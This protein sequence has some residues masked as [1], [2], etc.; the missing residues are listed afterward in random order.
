MFNDDIFNFNFAQVKVALH[1]Y[2]EAEEALLL[3]QNEKY[4][5]EYTYISHL[6][7]CC[8]CHVLLLY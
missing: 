5:S 4:K 1:A 7:K 2:Q 3:I 8:M 6:V